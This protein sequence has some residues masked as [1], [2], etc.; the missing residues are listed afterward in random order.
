MMVVPVPMAVAVA[1]PV[2]VIV[3]RI[4]RLRASDDDGRGADED[5]QQEKHEKAGDD[6]AVPRRRLA[7]GQRLSPGVVAVMIAVLLIPMRLRRGHGD[8][9][10]R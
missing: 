6:L 4:G 7:D 2:S 10:E 5:S 9:T 3:G 8:D 1:M